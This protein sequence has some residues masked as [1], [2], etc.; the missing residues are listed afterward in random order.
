MLVAQQPP[1]KIPSQSPPQSSSYR[2][3]DRDRELLGVR[4]RCLS[5][6]LPIPTSFT[7][8]A[9]PTTPHRR[10]SPA[11]I[12]QGVGRSEEHTSEL[13]SHHDLVCLL[14]LEKKKR[15]RTVPRSTVATRTQ[16]SFEVHSASM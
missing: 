15:R 11:A 16:S 14:L 6:G 8:A 9:C 7:P 4:S 10:F 13:Q 3:K 2:E 5:P 1:Q 12:I